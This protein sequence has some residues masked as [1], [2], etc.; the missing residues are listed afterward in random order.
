MSI[1]SSIF[2][3]ALDEDGYRALP[4][5]LAREI[6]G[7]AT[8]I[9]ELD[10]AKGL[11]HSET[12]SY[13][14][15][16]FREHYNAGGY[17]AHDPWARALANPRCINQIVNLDD[18]VSVES[19]KKSVVFNELTKRYGDDTAHCISY[20]FPV[21]DGFVA[22]GVQNGDGQP[23]DARAIGR[24]R[25]LAPQI[26]SA[27]THRAV[28]REAA[29]YSGVLEHAL[30]G[31][32][33]PILIVDGRMQVRFANHAAE[34]LF[35]DRTTLVCAGGVLSAVD[36]SENDAL[37]AAVRS[38]LG[39]KDVQPAYI[40]IGRSRLASPMVASIAPSAT[41]A[42]RCVT[43]LVSDPSAKQ[44]PDGALLSSVYGLTEAEVEV[45][46]L[47]ATDCSPEQISDL[48]AVSIAT[49]R[50][51]IRSVLGK[52]QSRTLASLIALANRLSDIRTK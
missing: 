39:Q 14:S 46:R 3:A 16:A 42:G 9:V 27:F 35:S 13:Y 52:T 38:T 21:A 36:A 24:L 11:L 48:R 41:P 20:V 50:T 2:E 43:I 40:G 23:F 17:I 44:K 5:K 30:H 19:F 22:I 7:R 28:A 4:S 25:Q 18:H 47:L 45:V 6:G 49:V 34:Q 1:E 10:P 33:T 51:Q 31:L 32:G 12:Y 15:Q 26:R 29:E 37:A 8:I